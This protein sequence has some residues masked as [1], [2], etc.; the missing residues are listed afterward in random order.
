MMLFNL[1]TLLP[2]IQ[3]SGI[4]EYAQSLT[5][6][7]RNAQERFDEPP[8]ARG[9]TDLRKDAFLDALVANMSIRE[10]GRFFHLFPVPAAS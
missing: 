5:G 3:L 10:L 2:A 9:H 1:S 6:S 8:G 4:F 7:S